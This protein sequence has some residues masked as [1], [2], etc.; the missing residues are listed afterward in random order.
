MKKGKIEPAEK[1]LTLQPAKIFTLES[2]GLIGHLYQPEKN[3]F[4]GKAL[5]MAGGSD[6]SF[7]LT[8]LVAEQFVKKGLTV[9]AVAYWNQPGLPLEYRSVPI[10]PIERSADWLKNAGYRK[11]G[12]WG[13]SMGA[14]LALIAGSRFTDLISCVVAVCPIHI[15]TQ[16]IRKGKGI[17]L[18]NCSAWS[19]QEKQLPYAPLK[20]SKKQIL[21]DSLSEK[22]LCTRSCY[23]YSLIEAPSDSVIKVEKIQGPILFLSAKHDG[24]WPAATAAELMMKRL[25]DHSFSYNY[26]HESYEYAS[27]FLIPYKLKLVK[28]FA[29]ERK[30]PEKCMESDHAAFEKTLQFLRE[31]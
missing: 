6:G 31:W 24:M 13:I 2:H 4:D 16:G 3:L 19:Y 27:H 8:C 5:I 28:I 21:K 1:L 29:V 15:C 25:Q 23:E 20:L 17:D 22:G 7:P 11:I 14:E 10:E 18:L 12:L 9:L 26:Q 30:Y